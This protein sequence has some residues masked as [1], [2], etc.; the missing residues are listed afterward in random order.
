MPAVTQHKVKGQQNRAFPGLIVPDQNVTVMSE[1]QV[2]F[3]KLLKFCSIS[4]V[5]R[6]IFYSFIYR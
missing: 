6:G 2:Q 1:A 3:R 5:I 4:R